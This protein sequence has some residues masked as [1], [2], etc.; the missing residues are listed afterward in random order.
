MGDLYATI[1]AL[2]E[3]AQTRSTSGATRAS[4]LYQP[5]EVV[6][7]NSDGT[8][9]VRAF[10]VVITANPETDLPLQPGQ[11]VY[12]SAV[13]NGKPVVHGPRYD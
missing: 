3:K 6:A 11:P 13:R 7:V 9:Q 8:Y 12:V 4:D 1:M 2:I 10:G 5:G